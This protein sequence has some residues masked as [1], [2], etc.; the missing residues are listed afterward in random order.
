MLCI[1][2]SKSANAA[3][4]VK[5]LLLKAKTELDRAKHEHVP[6]QDKAS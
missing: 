1:E 6:G 5:N 4:V 2:Q 3:S